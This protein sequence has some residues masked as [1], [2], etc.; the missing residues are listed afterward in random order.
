MVN[1]CRL[2]PDWC[3]MAQFL[4]TSFLASVVLTIVANV[5]LRTV[6]GLGERTGRWLASLSQ[7]RA[8]ICPAALRAKARATEITESA[9]T[10]VMRSCQAGV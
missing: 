2:R 3:A 7:A 6:P 10:P 4:W 9:L 1:R 5:A 8:T